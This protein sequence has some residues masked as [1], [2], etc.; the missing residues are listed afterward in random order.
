MGEHRFEAELYAVGGDPGSWVF[1][2]V[3]PA[4][5]DTID[6]ELTAPPRGFGSVRVEATLGPT[7]WRTS[8]FPSKR[9]GTYVLPVKRAVRRAAD[10]E[11]GDLGSFTLLV[12]D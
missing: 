6:E 5:A 12:L 11:P 1:V 7:T 9:S 2:D 4:L 8:L 10:V 3:P